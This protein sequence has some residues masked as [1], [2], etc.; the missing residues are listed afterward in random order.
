[1]YMLRACMQKETLRQANQKFILKIWGRD[2][3]GHGTSEQTAKVF[4]AK[5]IL[6][7]NLRKFSALKVFHYMVPKPVLHSQVS[8]ARPSMDYFQWFVR[9][10][11]DTSL[12]L[13]DQNVPKFSQ[14]KLCMAN[15]E[16]L[17]AELLSGWQLASSTSE[18][19]TLHTAHQSL[20]SNVTIAQVHRMI[21]HLTVHQLVTRLTSDL[22]VTSWLAASLDTASLVAAAAI[23]S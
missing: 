12:L 19:H 13:C 2:I 1:M 4:S 5:I 7:T 6:S 20:P 11:R 15:L 14:H 10:N 3:L 16:R 22:N 17:Q 21:F 23:S 8:Q 9:Q 18:L